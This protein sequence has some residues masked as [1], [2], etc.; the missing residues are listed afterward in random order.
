MIINIYF[1]NKKFLKNKKN[2]KKGLQNNKTYITIKLKW[3]KVEQSGRK[4]K[5]V[6]A[7]ANW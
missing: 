6:V 3:R 2:L 4:R 1:E 5:G 7:I